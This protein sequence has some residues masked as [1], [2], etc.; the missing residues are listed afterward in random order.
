MRDVY[1]H[2][3]IKVQTITNQPTANNMEQARLRFIATGA[4]AQLRVK[5]DYDAVYDPIHQNRIFGFSFHT[6]DRS[7]KLEL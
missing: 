3:R 4:I 1:G 5:P 6:L 2:D 7:K